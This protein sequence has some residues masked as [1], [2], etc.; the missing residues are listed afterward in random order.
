MNEG[1]TGMRSRKLDDNELALRIIIYIL[2]LEVRKSEYPC[3]FEKSTYVYN[4]YFGSNKCTPNKGDVAIACTSG[5]LKLNEFTIGEINEVI[6]GGLRIRDFKT[7]RL[8]DYRN[9]SFLCIK[10]AELGFK[11]K[12][13]LEREIYDILYSKWCE[14]DSW[15]LFCKFSF[16]NN[17]LRWSVRE[18]FTDGEY[19]VVEFD[20]D[21]HM[22]AKQIADK[23]FDIMMDKLEKKGGN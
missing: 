19:A 10:R 14:E 13:G 7:G 15:L 17:H 23:A 1:E 6:D 5:Y 16:E 11:W 4:P 2:S 18:K 3:G 8:C 9:E 22:T 12:F 20:A 21:D